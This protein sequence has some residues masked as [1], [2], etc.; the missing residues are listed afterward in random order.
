[1]AAGRSEPPPP[2]AFPA[3]AALEEP[4]PLLPASIQLRFL[5]LLEAAERI[6]ASLAA[7]A[8]HTANADRGGA[9]QLRTLTADAAAVL[10]RI[11]VALSARRGKR[12]ERM[13]DLSGDAPVVAVA[14][15]ASRCMS[16]HAGADLAHTPSLPFTPSLSRKNRSE[17]SRTMFTPATTGTLWARRSRPR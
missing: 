16:L 17:A 11:A 8:A 5:D 7:M 4:N 12:A 9:E 15:D 1:V 10:G 14:P 13:P 6:R 2:I 3:A